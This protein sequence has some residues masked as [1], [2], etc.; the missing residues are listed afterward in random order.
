MRVN[1]EATL[2]QVKPPDVGTVVCA[3][4][5]TISRKSR[6]ED[7]QANFV[8]FVADADY[9]QM[10]VAQYYDGPHTSIVTCYLQTAVADPRGGGALLGG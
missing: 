8:F 4:S 3:I 2:G 1:P 7:K 5:E 9:T 6:V 10:Y